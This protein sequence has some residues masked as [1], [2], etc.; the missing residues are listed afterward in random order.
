MTVNGFLS[1]FDGAVVAALT[2][3][4]ARVAVTV[5]VVRSSVVSIALVVVVRETAWLL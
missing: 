3:V 4:F 1:C 2:L 5:A